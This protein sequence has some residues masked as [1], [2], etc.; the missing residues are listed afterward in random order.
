MGSQQQLQ[1]Q[2]QIEITAED[3]KAILELTKKRDRMH[4]VTQDISQIAVLMDD[5][6]VIVNESQY[7]VDLLEQNV[8][9]A[10]EHFEAGSEAIHKAKSYRAKTIKRKLIM[11]TV[12][13]IIVAILLL[14]FVFSFKK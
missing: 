3:E 12:C 5:L 7:N 8:A 14:V 13:I 1:L 6:N 11:M 10:K 4:R 2:K 9:T